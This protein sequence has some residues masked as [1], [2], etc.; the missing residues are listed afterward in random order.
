[1]LF[2]DFEEGR[3]RKAD[4]IGRVKRLNVGLFLVNLE[5]FCTFIGNDLFCP[6]C[7]DSLVSVDYGEYPSCFHIENWAR[8]YCS[9]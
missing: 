4:R 6:I 3:R 1:M 9:E 2:E 7:G 8:R 5:L